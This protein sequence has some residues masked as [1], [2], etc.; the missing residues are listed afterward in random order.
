MRK[1]IGLKIIINTLILAIIAIASV[2]C[3]NLMVVNANSKKISFETGNGL[4]EYDIT[5]TAMSGDGS[6]AN[7]YIVDSSDDLTYMATQCNNNAGNYR[8]AYYR[9][10]T[11]L[12]C[13]SW[14]K[15]TSFSG[16]YDGCGYTI[17]GF[18]YSSTNF[19]FFQTLESTAVI[20]NVGFTNVSVNVSA[21]GT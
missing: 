6:A 9:Q 1:K 20:K 5:L 11:D 8:T 2:F 19:A 21:K 7:P 14:T 18:S 4:G 3:V 13:P 16:V 17:S 15:I 12:T 10:V